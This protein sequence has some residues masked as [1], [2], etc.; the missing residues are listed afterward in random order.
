M[1]F[2]WTCAFLLKVWNCDTCYPTPNKKF[3]AWISWQT[4]YFWSQ[5]LTEGI[6]YSM[7]PLRKESWDL[8]PDFTPNI[9]FP[10]LILISIIFLHANMFTCVYAPCVRGSVWKPEVNLE[11]DKSLSRSCG[12]SIRMDC[13]TSCQVNFRDLPVPASPALELNTHYHTW[14]SMWVLR[15]LTLD[16]VEW[17]A[18]K[19]TK[20]LF[21]FHFLETGSHQQE[22]PL[23]QDPMAISQMLKL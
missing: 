18:L 6:K 1:W 10:L 21:C 4:F 15:I 19:L 8:P 9:I 5:F 7:I 23:I 22:W 14:L 20:P 12:W 2:M 16:Q 11:W 13:L 17:Q 3:L